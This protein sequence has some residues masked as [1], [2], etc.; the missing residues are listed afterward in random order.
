MQDFVIEELN[1]ALVKP[2]VNR[3]LFQLECLRRLNNRTERYSDS[4]TLAMSL[5][6]VVVLNKFFSSPLT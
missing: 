6:A 4:S 2:S 1:K 3:G 5:G